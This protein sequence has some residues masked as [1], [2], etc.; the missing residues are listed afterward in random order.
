[1]AAVGGAHEFALAHHF[2]IASQLAIL[3]SQLANALLLGF[4]LIASA[5]DDALHQAQ[6]LADL[7]NTQALGLD[8][9]YDLEF[10]TRSKDSSGFLILDV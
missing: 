6:I 9:L 10:E 5:P 2:H 3:K 1:M 7:P 8:H 4:N